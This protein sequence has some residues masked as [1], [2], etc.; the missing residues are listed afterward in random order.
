MSTINNDFKVKHGL[1]VLSEVD[2]TSTTTGSVIVAGGVGIAKNLYIGGNL[3]VT[4][5]ITSSTPMISLVDD[6]TTNSNAFYPTMAYNTTSGELTSAYLS[7]TKFYY[8]PSTGSLTSPILK[9]S[10]TT[11]TAPLEVASAT[12]VTNLNADLLDD[13]QGSYYSNY[14]NLTNK[15]ISSGTEPPLTP[16]SDDLWW[17]TDT[18]TLFIYYFD[19]SSYQWVEATPHQKQIL[20]EN[21][22]GTYTLT[23][24]LIIT[25]D[26]TIEGTLYETSD[27]RLKNN[28]ELISTPLE[29]VQKLTGVTFDWIKTDK[30]SMGLIAQEVEQVIPYLVQ[31]DL[32]DTKSINYTA[33]IGLLVEAIKELNQ[34]LEDNILKNLDHLT[35]QNLGAING[36]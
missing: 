30:H 10:V 11:G 15:P 19:G 27:R 20:V 35:N 32:N 22:A 1:V 31:T 12:L 18:G 36:N 21:P 16:N 9:S 24:N 28:I 4:G 13:Q 17:D 26:E 2:A 34:K 8:N 23:G 6:I 29:T 5:A 33:I 3:V 14:R 25:G 7:S